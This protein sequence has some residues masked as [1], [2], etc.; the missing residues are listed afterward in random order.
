MTKTIRIH[1]DQKPYESPNPTTG[2]D[3]YVLGQIK[4]GLK[5][6]REVKGDQEDPAIENGP[7]TIH[8]R[9]DEHF[10][11]GEPKGVTIIVEGTPHEWTKPSIRAPS[12]NAVR[13]SRDTSGWPKVAFITCGPSSLLNRFSVLVIW[14]SKS[15]G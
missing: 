10:H 4:P 12:F 15:L 7:E 5:L 14:F 8:L 6:Y 1:I 3:L 9:E 11:S 2:A 13:R